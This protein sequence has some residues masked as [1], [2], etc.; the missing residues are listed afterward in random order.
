[1]NILYVSKLKNSMANGVTVAVLS[2]INSISNFANI[3]WLD[4]G[5]NEFKV[6]RKTKIISR[7]ELNYKKYDI[8]VFEDPFNS[9]EFSN[10]SKKLRKNNI[11]YI[12]VPHG[13]FNKKALNRKRIKKKIAIITIFNSFFKNATA[14]QFLTKNELDN[15][16]SYNKSIIIPNG[17]SDTKYLCKSK[18]IKNIIYVG[19][20][21]INHKGLDLLIKACYYIRDDLISLNV[22]INIYGPNSSDDEM[23]NS[24]IS[25]Y[26]LNGIIINNGPLFNKEK[27]KK[28]LCADAF[29][30]T[31]RYEGFP[32]SLLEAFSYG[33]PVLITDGTNLA[34]IV[35]KNNAGFTC[36]TSIDEI[37][38]MI[39]TAIYSDDI[40]AMCKNSKKLSKFYSWDSISKE[41]LELYSNLIKEYH[42]R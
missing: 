4:L 5:N 39:K 7:K 30:Q 19:R 27:E 21:D 18:K 37:S 29:I 32:M 2:L 16:I 26:K 12:I 15:S 8:A 24:M 22:T 10:I 3:F 28:L 41:T 13:C 20:K 1:M 38:S 6:S 17:I 42:E 40:S 31:S 34:Q 9:L 36:K 25:N 33:L 14:V 23:I 11:P 35:Q